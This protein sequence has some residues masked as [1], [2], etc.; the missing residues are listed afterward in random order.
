MNIILVGMPGAGKGTVSK[1]LCKNH[2]FQHIS[3]GDLL[4]QEVAAATELGKKVEGIMNRGELISDDL[5]IKIIKGKIDEKSQGVIFDG[6]PRTVDQAKALSEITDIGYV[7]FLR[8]DQEEAIRRIK[9]RMIEEGG[10]RADDREEVIKE[11]LRV[12][13][14]KTKPLFQYYE[15]QKKLKVVDATPMI[16]QVVED[17]EKAIGLR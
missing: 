11:R 13:D 12:Y 2:S 9:N 1:H 8:V 16:E 6:F 15:D 5:M 4:R 7:V 17:V 14:E 3:T 10:S